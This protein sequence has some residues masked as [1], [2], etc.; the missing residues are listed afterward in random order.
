MHL[1]QGFMVTEKAD[2]FLCCGATDSSRLL[3][4]C[5]VQAHVAFMAAAVSSLHSVKAVC[6]PCGVPA[7]VSEDH[8]HCF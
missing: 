8:K 1:V 5:A 4:H 6:L 3:D 2:G 7:Q